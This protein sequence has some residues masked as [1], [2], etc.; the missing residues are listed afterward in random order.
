MPDLVMSA[1]VSARGLDVRL[2][3]PAGQVLAV[4]GPN[5]AGKSTAAAV[6][7][8]LLTADDAVVRVG[9]RTLTDTGSGVQ[10]PSWQRRVGLLL[11]DPLLFPHLSVLGNVVFA[12]RRTH[13]RSAARAAALRWLDALGLA[14]LAGRCPAQLSGGQA[15]R[16]AVA[17]ALA[18]EPEVLV[19]DEPLAGLDVDAAAAVRA[20][21]RTVT[22]TG[23]RPTVLITHDV[24]DVLALADRIAVLDSGAVVEEGSVSE[25]LAA[26]RS[27]FAAR[28]AGL[29]LV[30]GLITAPGVLTDADGQ[31]WHG[32]EAQ[33][34]DPGEPSVAVFP[35]AAV[36]VYLDRPHGS[37]RNCVHRRIAAVEATGA[38][39]RLRTDAGSAPAGVAADITADAV[40][41]L[42]L[43]V[44]QWVWLSVKAQSV[45]LHPASR[46]TARGRGD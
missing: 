5:G 22:T 34:A 46:G 35:P 19:L 18:A 29:N 12:A 9:E 24:L 2:E 41:D 3:V 45:G 7:A 10:V 14:D 32:S 23:D 44:G 13:G 6:V 40:A 42:G 27:G 1:R 20:L 11:Q 36:S 39:I 17:R 8:G 43:A 33:R 38:A 21:L 16:V 31:L 4:L 37:P 28:M 30:P 25:V 26:P 15:Q